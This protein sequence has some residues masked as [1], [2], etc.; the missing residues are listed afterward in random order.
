MPFCIYIESKIE[1]LHWLKVYVGMLNTVKIYWA[2]I[3]SVITLHQES[4]FIYTAEGLTLEMSAQLIF[5]VFDMPTS[6]TITIQCS[7]C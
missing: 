5:T 3:L 1:R 7:T 2:D 4:A 6:D